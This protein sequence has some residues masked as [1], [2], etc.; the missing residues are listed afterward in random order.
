MV[1]EEVRSDLRR[2]MLA[3]QLPPRKLLKKQL[4]VPSGLNAAFISELLNGDVR[5][6]KTEIIE[7]LTAICEK[8]AHALKK[9]KEDQKESVERR[10][11]AVQEA[12][13]KI[14]PIKNVYGTPDRRE[15]EDV[16]DDMRQKILDEGKRTGLSV[17]RLFEVLKIKNINA[18]QIAAVSHGRQRTARIKDV[19]RTIEL[20]ET[21]PTVD[22]S[23]QIR[24]RASV[25]DFISDEIKTQ[26]L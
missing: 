12:R 10:R 8:E 16:P 4:H 9:V 20:Y 13:K 19:E 11:L 2:K 15:Y 22:R 21:M 1:T 23:L 6:A 14:S 3:T 5:Q 25:L 17:N 18:A 7:Y 26:I 24:V